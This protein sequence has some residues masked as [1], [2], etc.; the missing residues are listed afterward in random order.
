MQ[1]ATPEESPDNTQR[2]A[3]IDT[4][5]KACRQGE[6]AAVESLLERHPEVLDSPDFDTRFTYPES[7]LWSPLF[8]AAISGHGAL[9]RLLLDLGANPVPYEVAA[10]YHD[11][12]YHDWM[13]ELHGRGH[14]SIAETIEAGVSKRYGP[15]AD[16][17]NI[18]QVVAEGDVDLLRTLVAEKPERVQQVDAVGNTPLHVAVWANNSKITRLLIECGAPIDARNGDGRTPSVVALFGFHRWWRNELKQDILDL[19]MEGGADYTLL[20]AATLGDEARV[21]EL[22]ANDHPTLAN[23]ADPCHRRPLSGAASRGHTE[24]VRLLLENGA[25]P[26]A[27]EAI[28]QGGLALHVAV[29]RGYDEIVRL[30]LESGANPTHF[31]DS[32]GDSM[33]AAYH[34]GQQRT[35][36]LLYAYGGTMEF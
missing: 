5:G 11:N 35:L 24:V 30:L 27:K 33:F 14:A 9:V 19:L 20:M 12:T 13:G 2:V 31:V 32:S 6:I 29:W 23:D 28:C 15:L 21:R 36:Q 18:R 25:D 16:E 7:R 26:N 1:P 17:A 22:L 10:Q 4:L 3:E 34:Q 8:L